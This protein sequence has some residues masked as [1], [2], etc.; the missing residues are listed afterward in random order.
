MPVA[1]R[2]LFLTALLP[3]MSEPGQE[4]SLSPANMEEGS[5]PQG[6][7]EAEVH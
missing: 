4:G 1:F 6:Q 7:D 2:G 3:A 5:Q